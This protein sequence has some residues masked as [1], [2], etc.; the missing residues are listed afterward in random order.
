MMYYSQGQEQEVILNYFGNRKGFFVDI[1]AN[2]G[3]TLSNV[4]ALA[5]LGW[6]GLCIEPEEIAFNRLHK[7]YKKNDKVTV[8]NGAASTEDGLKPFYASGEHLKKGD[9]G[10]LSSL[11]Q[12]ETK[13]WVNEKFHEQYVQCFT[14]KRIKEM[15]FIDKIE[16]LS[17]DAEGMDYEILK[18]IDLNDVEVICIEHNS[19][20]DQLNNIIDYCSKFGMGRKLLQNLENIILTR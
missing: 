7:L 17:I 10:L 13:R 15:C 20:R 18:Q 4:R 6:Y 19:N 3:Q 9:I 5:L 16:F 11:N 1:G 2:D 14:W 12:S 8:L